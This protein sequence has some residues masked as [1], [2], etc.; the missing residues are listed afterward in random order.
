MYICRLLG[1]EER[2]KKNAALK[3]INSEMSLN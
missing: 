2:K 3:V 1:F